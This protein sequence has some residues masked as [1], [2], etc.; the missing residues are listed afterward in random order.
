MT[1]L[2]E[3][4]GIWRRWKKLFRRLRRSVL[5]WLGNHETKTQ[6]KLFVLRPNALGRRR[7]VLI[8]M[9]HCPHCG[10]ILNTEQLGQIRSRN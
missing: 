5:C 10:V 4:H 1:L 9:D 3:Q 8:R 6:L 2:N 7:K